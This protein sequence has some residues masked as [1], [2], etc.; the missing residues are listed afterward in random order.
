MTGVRRVRTGVLDVAF[1]RHGEPDGWPVV[2]LHGFPYD[3]RC[4]DEVAPSL[5][6]AGA[7]VVVP[8]LRGYGPT[9]FL[10]PRTPRSGQQTALASDLREL[11]TELGLVSP[12][13]AGFDWG[14]R[15]A[16]VAAALWP[17]LVR[18]LVTVSGYNIQNIL[19]AVAPAP[20]RR[21]DPYGQR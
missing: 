15:A 19:A 21:R 10:D 11:I 9:G 20:G 3:V 12:I 16:C 6:A 2:L 5:A 18:A 1:E 7:Y 14:G 17:Q 13:V 8:Y 4:Y